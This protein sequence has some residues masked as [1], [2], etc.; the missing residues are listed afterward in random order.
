[1]WLYFRSVRARAIRNLRSKV[2]DKFFV[3]IA[4]LLASAVIG[5]RQGWQ[6]FEWDRAVITF[7]IWLSGYALYHFLWAQWEIYRELQQRLEL[8]YVSRE[9][10]A[11]LQAC[12]TLFKSA[13]RLMQRLGACR[14]E[15]PLLDPEGSDFRRQYED[16][17]ALTTEVFLT[18]VH[19]PIQPLPLDAS[20]DIS[21]KDLR[22]AMTHH[23]EWLRD[24]Q[25]TLSERE[26][27]S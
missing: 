9:D 10:Y 27:V 2:A 26:R 23:V 15:R 14:A 22:L 4:G 7:A 25:A 1:M 18:V 19:H 5:L 24:H 13:C 16:Y 12:K 8:S 17:L 21:A 6:K 3:L 20:S 11:R